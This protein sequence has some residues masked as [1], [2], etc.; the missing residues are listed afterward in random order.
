[1]IWNTAHEFSMILFYSSVLLNS[2][3]NSEASSSA[4]FLDM[5]KLIFCFKDSL[6]A[7]DNFENMKKSVRGN[8]FCYVQVFIFWKSIQYTM[9]WGKTQMLKKIIRIKQALQKMPFL[10][11]SELQLITVLFWFAILTWAETQALSL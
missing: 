1:M 3:T 4:F 7:F 8:V 10:F 11:F 9:H 2:T 6:K 5:K